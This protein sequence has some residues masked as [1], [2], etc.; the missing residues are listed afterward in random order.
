MCHGCYCP[1]LYLL[2][3][4]IAIE[5]VGGLGKNLRSVDESI[6]ANNLKIYEVLTREKV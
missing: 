1:P 5:A 3:F 4:L 2:P 6:R